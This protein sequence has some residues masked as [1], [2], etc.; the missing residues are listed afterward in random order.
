M[1]PKVALITLN[2]CLLLILGAV[3]LGPSARAQAVRS[4]GQYLM[5]GGKYVLNQAGVAYIL[6]QSN[7]EL[8]SLSWNDGSKNLFGVGYKSISK[9]TE[10][11]QK[12]R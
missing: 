1:K 4:R 2:A 7:Q 10:Q 5:V 3:T 9:L 8:V 6:D 12:T 11:N